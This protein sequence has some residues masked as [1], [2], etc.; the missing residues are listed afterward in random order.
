[1]CHHHSGKDP[2]PPE[3][4]PPSS[5]LLS[6]SLERLTGRG[7]YMG[8]PVQCSLLP[9]SLAPPTSP[10]PPPT[11][12][13]SETL[14]HQPSGRVLC[15]STARKGAFSLPSWSA[16]LLDFYAPPTAFPD[17]V[18][19][20]EAHCPHFACDAAAGEVAEGVQSSVVLQLG[21]VP[22]ALGLYQE[23][24]WATSF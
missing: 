19:S 5:F 23:L 6:T 12:R 24:W 20:P 17:P 1:M 9:P 22:P 2:S 4:E 8:L 10:P 7:S 3:W 14:Q 16:L 13:A 18:Q 15:L 21:L 11:H